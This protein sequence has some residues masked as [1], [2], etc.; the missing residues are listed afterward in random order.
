MDLAALLN[1]NKSKAEHV[2]KFGWAYAYVILM[3]NFFLP[4]KNNE[5][6]P[7]IINS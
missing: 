7:R 4:P 2:T 6:S 5:N 1:K 3:F